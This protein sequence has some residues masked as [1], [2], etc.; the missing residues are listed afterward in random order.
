MLSKTMWLLATEHFLYARLREKIGD[1]MGTR[2]V[3]SVQSICPINNFNSFQW[4]IIK[5]CD[6]VC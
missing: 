2:A 6:I 4:I 5:L 1:I 3:G